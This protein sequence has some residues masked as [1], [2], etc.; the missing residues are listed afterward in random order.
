MHITN[1][2]IRIDGEDVYKNTKTSSSTR[3]IYIPGIIMN[4]INVL[5]NNDDDE[6]LIKFS[7]NSIYKRFT[8]ILKRNNLPHFRFHDLRHANASVMLSLNIPDKYAMERMGHSSTNMLKM[9]YQHTLAEENK[10]IDDKLEEYFNNLV[11]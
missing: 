10:K 2:L 9:V 11:D 5:N 1:A 4:K 7:A 3:S 6:Y 8:S